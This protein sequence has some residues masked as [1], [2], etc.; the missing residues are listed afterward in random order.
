MQNVHRCAH[1]LHVNIHAHTCANVNRHACRARN[2]YTDVH[3]HSHMCTCI[4]THMCRCTLAVYTHWCAHTCTHPQPKAGFWS[5]HLLQLGAALQKGESS[6]RDL[7]R[8]LNRADTGGREVGFAARRPFTPIC[9]VEKT[10]KQ[11]LNPSGPLSEPFQ[12]QML[13]IPV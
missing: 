9:Q 1:T 2:V 5:S 10:C 7:T 4:D 8:G 13:R 12:L 6:Q 11:E 3:T